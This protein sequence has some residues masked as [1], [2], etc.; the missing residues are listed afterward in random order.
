MVRSQFN[1]YMLIICSIVILI[2]I[3]LLYNFIS[4]SHDKSTIK[5]KKEKVPL[6]SPRIYLFLVKH[7]IIGSGPLSKAFVKALTFLEEHIANKDYKYSIPWYIILGPSLSGK[8]SILNSLSDLHLPEQNSDQTNFNGCEWFM[9]MNGIVMEVRDTVFS[10]G[11]TKSIINKDW[12]LLS[13]LLAYF[14]PRKP[15][16]GIIL[17]LPVD[18]LSREDKFAAEKK[19][20]AQNMFDNLFWMQNSLN[21]R[22]PVYVLLTKCDL[23]EGFSSLCL[24]MS[25]KEK[26]QMFGWSSTYSADTAYT[27]S[28]VDEALECITGG[29]KKTIL[30]AA[31]N[32]AVP[33]TIEE[34]LYVS[35]NL[36]RLKDNLK[37]FTNSI[38]S[39]NK[40]GVELV[41]RGIYLT[42]SDFEDGR[43]GK[44]AVTLNP[45]FISTLGKKSTLV[46]FV[47]DLFCEKIFLEKNIA[48]PIIDNFVFHGTRVIAKRFMMCILGVLLVVG[49]YFSSKYITTK[50]SEF[51]LTLTEI[52]STLY[53]LKNNADSENLKNKTRRLLDYIFKLDPN[54]L[55]S[56][57]IPISWFSEI[58]NTI[59]NIASD[60]FDKA[61]VSSMYSELEKRA[62]TV[63]ELLK[64]ELSNKIVLSPVN[65]EEF[66][67]LKHYVQKVVDLEQTGQSYN[68]ILLEDD[69]NAIENL[70]KFLYADDITNRTILK[71]KLKKDKSKFKEFNLAR[72]KKEILRNIVTLQ[73]AFVEHCF[74]DILDK[75]FVSLASNIENFIRDVENQDKPVYLKDVVILYKKLDTV[76]NFLQSN[77]L[78]WWDSEKFNPGK[79]YKELLELMSKSS[80]INDKF[81]TNFR[82]YVDAAFID[83]KFRISNISSSI[84]GNLIAKGRHIVVSEP[85]KGL[86]RFYNDLQGILKQKFLINV[87]DQSI[88]TEID[89]DKMLLWNKNLMQQC[90]KVI[91]SYKDFNNTS[92]KNFNINLQPLYREMMKK[93]VYNTVKSIIAK[94]QII[95]DVS[96]NVSISMEEGALRRVCGD[97]DAV[98]KDLLLVAEF[99]KEDFA[100][101]FGQTEAFLQMIYAN[102]IRVLN[103]INALFKTNEPFSLRREMFD[104]WDGRIRANLAAFAVTDQ[105]ELNSYI[106]AQISRLTFLSKV[107]AEPVVNLLRSKYFNLA[108]DDVLLNQW[109]S[110]IEAVDN[111]NNK[112]P[113]NSISVLEMF[114]KKTLSE[115][116]LDNIV[117]E[118][119]LDAFL[120]I[121]K[122][123][124]LSK[125][126]NIARYLKYRAQ[127]LIYLNSFITYNRVARFFNEYIAGFF[128]FVNGYSNVYP[129]CGSEQLEN[130]IMQFKKIGAPVK[131]AL[132]TITGVNPE[133]QD[134][135]RFIEQI[136]NIMPFLEG[137]LQNSS[138]KTALASAIAFKLD[139]RTEKGNEIGGD[140]IIDWRLKVGEDFVTIDDKDKLMNWAVGQE[141][142]AIF[143]WAADSNEV[144]HADTKGL[145]D[146]L[147][148]NAV[149]KYIGN[150]ALIRL[151]KAHQALSEVYPGA[152]VTLLFRI[153]TVHRNDFKPFRDVKLFCRIKFFEKNKDAWTPIKIPDFPH[154]APIVEMKVGNNG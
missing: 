107:L 113:G 16:D 119:K 98:F 141:I 124:F 79:E 153:P 129:D 127:E 61:V 62:T 18:F 42:G 57:F 87:E 137:W 120:D 67:A 64:V 39:P 13:M 72:H 110:F 20:I 10:I 147:G 133:A 63:T 44:A 91:K 30:K 65:L 69:E 46:N 52:D 139:F 77:V 138:K 40:V 70:A 94:S 54:Q 143:Q 128:P 49:F 11:N 148:P 68:R 43:A 25:A 58:R 15:L 48:Q 8:S 75:V 123:F 14:R 9:F 17:T 73:K 5:V 76:I 152:G 3:I 35:D 102:Y 84:T 27:S 78:N 142:K 109:V 80:L 31:A 28:W 115:F 6:L 34:S 4:K 36:E 82:E 106:T 32:A 116:T 136:E 12:Q 99:F 132:A 90:T 85:S 117:N 50:T 37:L 151:I 122:D 41:L 86:M 121:K 26:E 105:E 66:K 2:G 130:F 24:G 135:L 59:H 33:E 134:A 81:I 92:L 22:L 83:F 95:E 150:W 111:Y 125:R 56:F 71:Q 7:G 126:A 108:T 131:K 19:I 140:Q 101:N 114:I 154:I 145:V 96:Q 53:Q 146:V 38:F 21:L 23:L 118:N 104:D 100:S 55:Y 74:S 45:E 1:S 103:T 51:A 144:P 29:L 89:D 47:K 149:F 88:I 112:T 60:A 97:L 93:L